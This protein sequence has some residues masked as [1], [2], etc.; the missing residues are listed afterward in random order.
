MLSR[1]KGRGIVAIASCSLGELSAIRD[2]DL[3]GGGAA[4]RA[5]T[6]HLLHDIIALRNFSEY[7]VFAIQPGGLGS[8][9]EELGS[10]GARASVGHGENAR[11]GVLQLEILILE[12]VAIDGLPSSPVASGEITTLAHK[13]GDDSVEGRTL[14]AKALLSSAESTEVLNG[15]GNN[16]SMERHDD[17]A[18]WLAANGDVKE[19]LCLLS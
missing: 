18:S 17:A 15:L 4:L 1:A 5:D 16:I 14:V 10:V 8:T 13:A 7:D 19:N 12:L 3:L 9:E 11:A 6:F 2:G